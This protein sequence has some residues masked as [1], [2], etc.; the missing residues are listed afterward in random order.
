MPLLCGK[1]AGQAVGYRFVSEQEVTQ[2]TQSS[3][4]TLSSQNDIQGA[5]DWVHNPG[6]V[7]DSCGDQHQ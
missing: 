4:L 1:R 2:M 7:V 3:S 5:M 6:K